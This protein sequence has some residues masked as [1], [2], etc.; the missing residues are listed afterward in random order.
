MCIV[1]CVQHIIQRCLL[2][3]NHSDSCH[4]QLIDIE[5]HTT[6]ISSLKEMS[7]GAPEAA[8][9]KSN[10]WWSRESE[11]STLAKECWRLSPSLMALEWLTAWSRTRAFLHDTHHFSCPWSY[12]HIYQSWCLYSLS[13]PW[14]VTGIPCWFPSSVLSVSSSQLPRLTFCHSLVSRDLGS[15]W[16]LC[17]F[18]FS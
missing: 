2:E 8:V 11:T 1:Y 12:A 4:P 16:D 5:C 9:Q 10:G 3:I 14:P 15:A 7:H 6:P 13:A 18:L 17:L